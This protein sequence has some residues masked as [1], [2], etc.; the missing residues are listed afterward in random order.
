MSYVEVAVS[1]VPASHRAR[2]TETAEKA[3]AAFMEH[4]ALAV[5]ENWGTDVPEGK[6]TD[7]HR[8]VQRQGNEVVVVSTILWPSK[9][10]RDAAWSKLMQHEAM[11]G[12]D[13]LMDMS[14]MIF[15]S[16]EQIVS[17]P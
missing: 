2:Y 12:H 1:A 17:K 13:D 5:T 10:V 8:A 6:T 11:T 9:T 4:G 15:G 14:R 3:A 16:F 7:F